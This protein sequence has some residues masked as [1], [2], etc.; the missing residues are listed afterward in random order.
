[1]RETS[2]YPAPEASPGFLLWRATLA[3][4]RAVRDALV[5]LG[6]THV[7]FVVLAAVA[8]L[9]AG[10]P[11]TQRV[12]ADHAGIDVMMASQVVRVLEARGLVERRPHP[13]D[14]RARQVVPTAAGAALA[15]RA[16]AVVEDADAVF[17]RPLDGDTAAFVVALGRLVGAGTRR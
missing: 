11:P 4:Q 3:W 10:E 6:L 9:A 16:L 7:Q 8:W 13:T 5:P 17:F 12:L 15:A 2:R 14:G 1:M